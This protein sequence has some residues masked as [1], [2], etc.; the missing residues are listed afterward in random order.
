[1]MFNN[2]DDIKEFALNLVKTLEKLGEKAHADDLKAWSGEFFTTSSEFLGELKLI[3][4]RIS[5]LKL[6]DDI[7]KKNVNECIRAINKAFDI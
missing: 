1:M 2:N 3:L 7:T 5:N 4:E 6:L